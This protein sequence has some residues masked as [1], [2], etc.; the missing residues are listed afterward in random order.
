MR[1][2]KGGQRLAG[3]MN[4]ADTRH[5]G[6]VHIEAVRRKDLR[7]EADIRE[8]GRFAETETG[9]CV[10]LCQDRFAGGQPVA[11]PPLAPAFDPV[12]VLAIVFAQIGQHAQVLKRVNIAGDDVGEG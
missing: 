4:S 10:P 3:F 2:G 7:N 9:L 12:L 6:E 11:D 5:G 1:L 8:A